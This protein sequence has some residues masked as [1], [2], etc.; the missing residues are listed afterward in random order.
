MKRAVIITAKGGNTS[1]EN[2]NVIPILGVP[3]VLFPVRAARLSALTE[4]VFVS[5]EDA[6]IRTLSEKEG[7]KIIH[8]PAELS[9]PTSQHK[10]VIKH[11]VEEVRKEHP[12]VEQFVVLLGNTVMVTPGLIDRCLQMLDQEDCDSVATVWKAQDD[13]PYR[14]LKINDA[15]YAESFLGQAVSSNRQSYPEV[16]FYDQGV[17]AFRTNCALEQKGPVPWVWLGEKCKLVERPWVTGRDIHSWI[18]VSASAWY[19]SAIQAHDFM[20]YKDL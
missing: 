10:D 2:K 17:W 11:A 18:A 12:E 5:T 1:V 7:A 15:G 3:V 8:R 13:H 4:N 14:A 6:M 19:L 20:D 16:Y 9:K